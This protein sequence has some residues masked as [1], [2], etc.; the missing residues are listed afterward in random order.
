MQAIKNHE[1]SHFDALEKE[2]QSLEQSSYNQTF[3]D[4]LKQKETDDMIEI[5]RLKLEKA[6]AELLAT[7]MWENKP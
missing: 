4:S 7:K 5:E 1:K 6:E 2:I 3:I